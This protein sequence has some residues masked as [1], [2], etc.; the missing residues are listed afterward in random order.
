[1]ILLVT[2]WCRCEDISGTV[3]ISCL[4]DTQG[5]R[6]PITKKRWIQRKGRIKK[7]KGKYSWCW[8]CLFRWN[9]LMRCSCQEFHTF[10]VHYPFLYFSHDSLLCSSRIALRL[11]NILVPWFLVKI[12]ENWSTECD[13]L[14]SQKLRKLIFIVD[15]IMHNK[16]SLLVYSIGFLFWLTRFL[17]W[18]VNYVGF[19][20]D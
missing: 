3:S 16:E 19:Q 20:Y 4:C 2:Y 18:L 5:A 12:M 9:S 11:F 17:V 7:S 15:K 10:C 8:I 13:N 1:M 6:F 14:A